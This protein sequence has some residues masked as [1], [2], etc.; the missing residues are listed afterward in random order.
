MKVKDASFRLKLHILPKFILTKY[1][2]FIQ[3]QKY[4]F[5]HY[6]TNVQQNYCTLCIN[7][8]LEITTIDSEYI[9]VVKSQ[10]GALILPQ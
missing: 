3:T 8:K 7:S 4:S 1:K 10:N 6:Y 5:I 9:L 2:I